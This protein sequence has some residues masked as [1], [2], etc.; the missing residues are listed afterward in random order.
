ML[1]Q[2]SDNFL[3]CKEPLDGMWRC[4]TEN[5][6]GDSIRDA[7]VYTKKYEK[8]LY[9]CLFR[10][11]TGLDMCMNHFTD[12]VRSIYRSPENELCDWN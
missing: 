4:Y 8:N 2:K 10:E 7:P 3:S 11:A 5:K 1:K 9:D 6:Y 12:M